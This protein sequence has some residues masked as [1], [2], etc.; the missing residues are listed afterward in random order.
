MKL[1]TMEI[2]KHLPGAKKTEN[3][4]C[5]KCSFPTCM[6]FALKVSSN[7]A[8]IS[9][10]PHAPEE[11]VAKVNLN[12]KVQQK[13]IEIGDLKIGGETVL[14]RHEKTFVS[15]TLFVISLKCDEN[16]QKNLK[17][18][19]DFEIERIG[20]KFKIQAVHLENPTPECIKAVGEAGLQNI[21]INLFK[22]VESSNSVEELT[23]I[24]RKAIIERDE[25]FSTPTLVHLKDADIMTLCAKASLLIC[26]YANVILFDV[27]DEALFSTLFTLRQNIF[28]D[29]EK[30][31]QVESK[32][33]E[34]NNPDENSFVFMTT[35]FALSYFAVLN[36]IENIKGGVYF[37]ITPSEGMS[38]LTAWSAEKI[39]AKI[40]A[41]FVVSSEKL[42]THKNKRMII[43]G[44]LSDLKPE[45][46][47]KMPDWEIISG[48]NEAYEIPSFM[49]TL[50]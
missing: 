21:D 15:P 11:L 28:T 17:R 22:N 7:K 46:E 31:L 37:V 16:F 6:A 49:K 12:S 9:T 14:F 39:T 36:E 8:D 34:I 32:V 33:Y 2:F 43:P 35:N 13:T 30:P 42:K 25:N 44:L 27:F 3:A 23:K 47:E 50:L 45:L 48:T 26:R 24:R 29:P 40:A 19:A 4:N 18:I 1:T 20:E 5:K 38:V 10:C 41:D